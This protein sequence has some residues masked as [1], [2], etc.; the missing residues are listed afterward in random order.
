MLKP[1]IMDL[2][3][4]TCLSPCGESEMVPTKIIS[5]AKE[6]NLSAI[7]VCDHNTSENFGA[8]RNVGE[9]HGIKV[10]GG[11]EITSQEEVHI[12][13]LF[14]DDEDLR[15]MQDIIYQNLTGINDSAAFGKQYIVDEEDYVI[16]ICSKLLIG[17]TELSIDEIIRHIHQ[18]SGLAIASHID[19]E[20]FSII[21][22]LGFIPP[23]LKLDALELSPKRVNSTSQYKQYEYPL[24]SFSDAHCLRDIGRSKTTFYIEY[25]KLDE[26]KKAFHNF[27]GRRIINY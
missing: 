5:H 25:A 1:Y 26:L 27:E 18:L 24:V 17:A 16:D 8:V 21:S 20:V 6:R 12:L 7:G 14:D 19:R 11:I 15:K 23:N 10:F 4:H 2:H 3:I 13:S 22:Q 9:K